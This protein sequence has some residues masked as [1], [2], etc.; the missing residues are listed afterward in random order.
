[1]QSGEIAPFL[2]WAGARPANHIGDGVTEH[3]V[4]NGRYRNHVEILGDRIHEGSAD[5]AGSGMVRKALFTVQGRIAGT[6]DTLPPP[7]LGGPSVSALQILGAE[8]RTSRRQF[9][10]R[11]RLLPVSIANGA[12]GYKSD[13]VDVGLR[14]RSARQRLSRHHRRVGGAQDPSGA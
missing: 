10:V 7:P 4:T 12:G 6:G 11:G 8:F 3:A 13:R 14:R 2:V 9:R 1:M 5:A